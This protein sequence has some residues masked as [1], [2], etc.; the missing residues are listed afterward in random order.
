MHMCVTCV[1]VARVR[2]L[3]FQIAGD[4]QRNAQAASWDEC[5]QAKG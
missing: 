2:A 3:T 5:E 1:Y 4:R